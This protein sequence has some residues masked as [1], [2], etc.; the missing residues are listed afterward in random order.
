M[1]VW[2][3]LRANASID[4]L[5]RQV[6]ARDLAH[7]WLLLGPSGSDKAAAATAIAAAVNCEVAPGVGCG[8]C[9]TCLRILRHRHPDVHHIAP[10]GTF[11]L[12]DQIR[13]S[14]ISE[15]SRSPFEGRSKVFIVE[16]ADRMNPAAQNALLKTLEEPGPGT[17]FVL[18]SAREEELLDTIRSRCRAVHLHRVAEEHIARVLTSEGI[19]PERALLAARVCE[20]DLHRAR[21]LTSS[22]PMWDRRAFWLS[23]PRR[24]ASPVDALDIA[25]EVVAEAREAVKE[26]ES[27]QKA[28]VADLAEAMGEGRGTAAAR[29]AL[30]KRHKRELRRVEESV[31]AEA[32]DTLGAFYRDVLALRFGGEALANLDVMDDLRG[33]AESD[34]TDLALLQAVERCVTARAS[35]SKNANVTLAVETTMLTLAQLAPPASKVGARR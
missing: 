34:L 32:L 1:T 35:L 24:L 22:D 7:A 26:R 10:E 11:I 6:S 15:A 28:E 16:E 19:P 14:V 5:A 25:A 2:D 9:S 17:L 8:D 27:Q 3:P 12:V 13:D 23:I 4:G 33:W 18:L 30:S 20:G 31:L 29:N 21:A